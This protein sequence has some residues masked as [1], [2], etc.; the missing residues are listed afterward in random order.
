MTGRTRRRRLL[1]LAAPAAAVGLML[2]AC[3][4][5]GPGSSE[6]V[7]VYEVRGVVRSVSGP[8]VRE[9]WLE[10]RH[11]AIPEFEGPDG[12]VEGMPA[13]SMEFKLAEG[14]SAAELAP[15]DRILFRLE[16]DWNAPR[17]AR[18]VAFEKLP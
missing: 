13:M 7:R 12:D 10:I 4:G 9:P 17:P 16:I 15:G 6:S 1:V 18:I 14:L 3:P 11:E 2:L 8:E 5:E